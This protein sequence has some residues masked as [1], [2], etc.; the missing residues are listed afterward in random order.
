M[1]NKTKW[2]VLTVALC[3]IALQAL[4]PF[5]HAHLDIEHPE[6]LSG[7]HVGGD[8]EASLNDHSHKSN[9]SIT[10][11]SHVSHVITIAPSIKQDTDLTLVLDVVALI[12]IS[13]CLAIAA[14]LSTQLFSPLHLSHYQSLKRRLPASRAPPQY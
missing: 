4:Q 11:L 1:F 14:Q 6:H 9:H 5:I 7:L 10:D 8:Y 3:L 13:F 12:F 2:L